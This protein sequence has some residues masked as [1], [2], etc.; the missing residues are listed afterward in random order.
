MKKQNKKCLFFL[1][2]KKRKSKI[3]P[4]ITCAQS[5]FHA[6]SINKNNLHLSRPLASGSILL[7][8][9]ASKTLA[10]HCHLAFI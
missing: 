3:Q 7:E 2:E 6:F 5:K 10:A 9:A 1:K 8:S 4:F